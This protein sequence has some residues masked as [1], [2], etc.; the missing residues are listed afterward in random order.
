MAGRRK[1]KLAEELDSTPAFAAAPSEEQSGR[2]TALGRELAE[3]DRSIA[4]L[5]RE[6]EEARK[7]STAI[8]HTELPELMTAIGQDRI[9]LPDD[10]V[11]LILEPFYHANIAADWPPEQREAGFDY[12]ASVGAEDLVKTNL[13]YAF[14]RSEASKAR[15]VAAMIAVLAQQLSEV[16]EGPEAVPRPTIRTDVAWNT[17]TAWMRDRVERGLEVDLRRIGGTVG[18]IVRIKPRG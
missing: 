3:V 5:E 12:L 16:G 6:L 4:R 1:S 18:R 17:L 9:G 8:R 2:L 14:G 11:D 10:R 15:W 7:R 13:S